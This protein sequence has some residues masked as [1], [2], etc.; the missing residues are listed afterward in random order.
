MKTLYYNGYIITMNGGKV[1]GGMLV[2]ENGKIE[3]AGDFSNVDAI[4][5]SAV[6]KVDLKGCVVMPSFIDSHSHIT[7]V[8]RTMSLADLNGARSDDDIYSL[9]TAFKTERGVRDGEWLVGYN[10]DH[11]V[12]KGRRH[13]DGSSRYIGNRKR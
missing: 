6:K 8:A 10:Y 3:V 11:N 9:L 12:M 13:P 4:P 5:D 2:G 7:A 1:V